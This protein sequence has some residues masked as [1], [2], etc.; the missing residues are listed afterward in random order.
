MPLTDELGYIYGLTAQDC[1]GV[2]IG[3][4]NQIP[5]DDALKKMAGELVVSIRKNATIDG[6]PKESVRSAMHT[7]VRSRLAKYDYPP[8]LRG[9]DIELT[10]EQAE[11]LAR[12]CVG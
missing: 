3:R 5:G 11:R 9:E 12:A 6:D 10:L 1:S 4:S 8:D 7:R 2:K